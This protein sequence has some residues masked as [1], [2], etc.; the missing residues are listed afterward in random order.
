MKQG[1]IQRVIALVVGGA[2]SALAPTLSGETPHSPLPALSPLIQHVSANRDGKAP[3]SI[4]LAALAGDRSGLPIGVFDSGIGG[5]TVLEAI[6]TI[7]AHNNKTLQP[8]ADGVP[9]FTGERF[10][11]LGDQANMPYGNYPSQGREDYLRELIV[12]D[13]VFLL[14]RRY[15]GSEGPRFDKPAVKAIVIACNTATAY[16]I[17]DIRG[18]LKAWGLDMPVI[19][20]VEA[21]ARAVVEQLPA[22]GPPPT[23]GI[24]ATVGTCA[25]NAYPKAIARA[26]GLAGKT[27][28]RVV[29]QG[30]IG[31]AGAIEGNPAFVWQGAGERPVPYAGPKEKELSTVAA[32]ARFDINR[33][34]THPNVAESSAGRMPAEKGRGLGMLVLGCTHFPLIER[35]LNGALDERRNAA[36]GDDLPAAVLPVESKVAFIN[37]AEQTAKELFRELAR[38]KLRAKASGGVGPA[39]TSTFF[40]SVPNPSAPDVKLAPDGSLAASYKVGRK[41]GQTDRED[42]KM[43]P[44]TMGTLPETSRALLEKLPVVSE[45]LKRTK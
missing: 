20:V 24:L 41:T 21:G 14:G 8:G 11:Y 40:I 22:D 2:I 19:G 44:M 30:S 25:S 5:L 18:A 42:T 12:K 39:P 27:V 35:E 3:N 45:Q 6:L 15:H 43:A 17:D 29:Q 38:G 28:P 32:Y 10:V 31:L 37:P 7:D 23:V 9:D 26:A 33:M 36:P 34:V 1:D 16:G 4:D 13:A